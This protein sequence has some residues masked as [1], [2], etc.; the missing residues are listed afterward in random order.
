MELNSP[1]LKP[2]R[3]GPLILTKLALKETVLGKE[4]REGGKSREVGKKRKERPL[5]HNVHKYQSPVS[6]I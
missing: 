6:A 2:H 3:K 1:D 5:L 4:E